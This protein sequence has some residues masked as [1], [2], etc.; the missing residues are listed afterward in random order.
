MTRLKLAAGLAASLAFSALAAPAFANS[1]GNALVH[2]RA[3]NGLTYMMYQNHMS[4]YYFDKDGPLTSNC[5]GE[6]AAKWPPATLPAGSQLGENYSL[7]QRADGSWQIAYKGQP[8]YL[9]AGDKRPGDINGD[10]VGG[11]WHVQK[12][13]N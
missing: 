7:F 4:L 10:G 1:H 6:C 12:P 2:S 13:T 3:F 9:Y 8:L 11:V 5:T